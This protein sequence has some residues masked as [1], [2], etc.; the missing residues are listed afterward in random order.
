M[1]RTPTATIQQR[2]QLIEDLLI[3]GHTPQQI[4]EVKG[5]NGKPKIPAHI[6]R[7]DINAIQTKWLEHDTGGSLESIYPG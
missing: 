3:E 6:L 7:P 4:L 1:P 2:R 5:E